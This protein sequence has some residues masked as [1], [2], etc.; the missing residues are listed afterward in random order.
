MH[1]RALHETIRL[2]S[3]EILCETAMSFSWGLT[4]DAPKIIT[5]KLHFRKAVPY[6]SAQFALLY[7]DF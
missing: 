7:S 6:S 4:N 3:C 2:Q 5:N 1:I